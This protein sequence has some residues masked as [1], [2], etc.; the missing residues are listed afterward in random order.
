MY[1]TLFIG[2]G[3]FGRNVL[4]HLLSS[5]AAKGLTL[6]SKNLK[7]IWIKD[8]NEQQPNSLLNY[9]DNVSEVMG[10]LYQDIEYYDNKASFLSKINGVISALSEA[11][12]QSQ[13]LD[14]VVLSHPH[15]SSSL[16]TL[17]G[18]LQES[19]KA[20]ANSPNFQKNVENAPNLNFISILDFEHY[21]DEKGKNLREAVYQ[22]VKT[23]QKR[24]QQ[25]GLSFRRIYLVDGHHNGNQY[26]KEQRIDQIS[27]FLEFLVFT[28]QRM[29]SN[30]SHFY[31]ATSASASPVCTFGIRL[32]ERSSERL[33]QL[34]AGYFAFR[35]LNFL[36]SGREKVDVFTDVPQVKE[37][38]KSYTPE[39]LNQHIKE[40][41]F[42][43]LLKNSILKIR[44]KILILKKE[45]LSEDFVNNVKT[46]YKIEKEQFQNKSYQQARIETEKL[47]KNILE[48]LPKEIIQAIDTDLHHQQYPVALNTVIQAVNELNEQLKT[49]TEQGLSPPPPIE[50]FSEL[51]QFYYQEQNFIENQVLLS[52]LKYWWLGFS[53][54]LALGLTY[55]ILP[56]LINLSSTGPF[57]WDKIYPWV[58]KINTPFGISFILGFLFLVLAKTIFHKRIYYRIQRPTF[59]HQH[60]KKGR[61]AY[62]LQKTLSPKGSLYEPLS[63]F[64]KHL[65][66]DMR[67]MLRNEASLVTGRIIFQLKSRKKEI[68][69]LMHQIKDFLQI[70]GL[71]IESDNMQRPTFISIASPFRYIV[72]KNTDFERILQQHIPNDGN[73]LATQST[74]EPFKDW[75]HS[76][77]EKFLE[78]LA[79]IDHLSRKYPDNINNEQK[80]KLQQSFIQFI[81]EYGG[82]SPSLF[83]K[84]GK[85]VPIISYHSLL[86]ETWRGIPNIDNALTG[87]NIGSAQRTQHSGTNHAYL[88]CTQLEI[89]PECLR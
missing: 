24:Q 19:I 4:R 40:T 60:N 44:E 75:Y 8:V 73:F 46:E 17:D 30:F 34:A 72:E 25:T 11:N 1:S 33:S 12:S 10:D 77:N 38:L 81:K 15:D 47:N 23:W 57:Y 13:G 89:A 88:I 80:E 39:K 84:Q 71:S 70:N 56:L 7:F 85:G 32:M 9:E 41:T 74:G 16:G 66:K 76:C 53:L 62:F 65:I 18:I 78:P 21:W 61:F 87:I 42:K 45:N 20:L 67:L 48:D 28:N 83:L 69:W 27:L 63:L 50:N 36:I 26:D 54:I 37:S 31:Q 14:V 82:F 29:N 55:V 68:E 2:Y 22:S 86:P 35:W 6:Q 51:K 79:F 52:P 43:V 58:Q 64:S 3:L 5:S 49:N 59:F